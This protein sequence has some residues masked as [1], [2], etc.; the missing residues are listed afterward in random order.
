MH[1]NAPRR[2]SYANVTSTLALVLALGGTSYAAVTITGRNI[3]NESITAADL[4]TG[5]VGSA[6]VRNGSLRSADFKAGELPAGPAG[7]RG[8]NGTP[9][10]NGANG[11]QGPAGPLPDT[12]PSGKTLRGAYEVQAAAGALK[13]ELTSFTFPLAAAPVSHVWLLGVSNPDPANC[14]GTAAD[15]QAAPG[16]VCVY[17][18]S[19]SAAGTSAMI[20][21]ANRFSVTASLFS[22]SGGYSAGTWAVTAP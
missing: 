2:I 20:V 17:E 5:S 10:A 19:K 4:A 21:S 11:V 14:T 7:P 1:R 8:A 18:G 15:P 9:G 13:D 16:H 22:A 3:R 12:L 6:E